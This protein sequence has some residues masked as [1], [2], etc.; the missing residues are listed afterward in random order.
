MT[1]HWILFATIFAAGLCVG[2]FLNL[3]AW[4]LP[5]ML[6]LVDDA[7]T[8]G[9]LV[10]PRSYCPACRAPIARRHLAPV[11]GFIALGGRCASCRAK[12]SLRYPAVELAGGGLAVMA[13]LLYG[14]TPL[15]LAAATFGLCLLL[16]AAI[17]SDTGYLPD[18]LTLPLAAAGLA[19]NAFGAFAAPTDA[20]IGALAGYGGFRALAAA[21]RAARGVDGL[22]RGDAKLLG[23]IGAWC[24]WAPLPLVVLIGAVSTLAFLAV[25]GSGGARRS[26]QDPVPFGPGL[27]LGGAAALFGSELFGSRALA[28]GL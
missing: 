10:A 11:V 6:G 21:F 25:R 13:A 7:R 24:G 5:A 12:I 18:A 26:L 27:C 1:A 14:W 8:R 4:R 19:V 22:G 20:A 3:A 23:A 2:S 9:T 16:L 28:A 15:A 17:D